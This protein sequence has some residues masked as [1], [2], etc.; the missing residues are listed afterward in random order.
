MTL[1]SSA[2]TRPWLPIAVALL[3][4]MAALVQVQGPPGGATGSAE[5][6]EPP[7]AQSAPAEATPDAEVRSAA[8]LPSA[9]RTA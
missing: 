3:S 5:R 6:C 1:D 4:A 9:C 7:A 2:P 8:A